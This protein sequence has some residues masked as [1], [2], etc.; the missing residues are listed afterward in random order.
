MAGITLH[1]ALRRVH[2]F[3]DRTQQVTTALAGFRDLNLVSGIGLVAQVTRLATEIVSKDIVELS[4]GWKPVLLPQETLDLVESYCAPF[5][6]ASGETWDYYKVPGQGVLYDRQNH[7]KFLVEKDSTTFLSHLREHLWERFGD[8]LLLVPRGKGPWDV[9]FELLPHTPC[10]GLSSGRSIQ[11]W[12]RIKP[13]VLANKPRSLMLDGRAGTGKT[14]IA[15]FVVERAME[16]QTTPRVLRI[17][18]GDFDYLSS[19]MLQ[20]LIGLLQPTILI[21]DD[22]DR[23]SNVEALLDF[24]EG[25]RKWVKLLVV[26]TNHLEKLSQAATRPQRFDEV[27]V[28]EGLGDSFVE[29]YLGLSLWERLT[30]EQQ[31]ILLPWPISFLEEFRSRTIMLPDSPLENEIQ[32]LKYRVEKKEAPPWWKKL[33]E[34]TPEPESGPSVES[35]KA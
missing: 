8:H 14:T 20:G 3:L 29:D 15:Q 28:V 4:K 26:T 30:E 18:T 17:P 10:Q 12:E 19:S 11:V 34:K 31:K 7:C 23:I 2:S 5:K 16:I 35:K 13:W 24:L 22:F 32:D 25:C 27:I 9:V 21:I 6:E 33:Q 1:A